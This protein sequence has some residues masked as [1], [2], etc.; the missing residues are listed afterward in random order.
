MPIG[1]K[2]TEETKK[3]IG[4]TARG[5][6]PWNK[7]KKFPYKARYGM[8]GKVSW[9][10]GKQFS[11]EHKKKL[12]LAKLG[13]PSNRTGKKFTFEQLKNLS[14]AH[15]GQIA[16]NRGMKHPE[17]SGE[18]H[19]AWKGGVTSLKRKLAVSTDWKEWRESIFVRDNYQC[20]DCGNKGYL[21]PHHIIPLKE[22]LNKIFDINNGI[23]LC[24]PC[25][26]KTMGK[27]MEL[28]RMYFSF[29]QAPVS[30]YEYR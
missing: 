27:E 4:E 1:Y 25:H 20:F 10:K 18:K 5:R 23:T 30:I 17:R 14:D 9:S 6:T 15:L 24:R 2:H 3:R 22:N 8:R 11:E 12:S 19:V 16:W 29:I 26:K 28:S 7:N 13:K 21:E